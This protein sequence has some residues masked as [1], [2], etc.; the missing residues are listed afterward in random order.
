MKTIFLKDTSNKKLL[1]IREF[2]A[3]LELTWKAWTTKDALDKWWAPKPWKADT[4][5]MD[6]KEGGYW[7][8]AMV[9]PAGEKHWA[10]AEYKKIIPE[11]MYIAYDSFCDENGNK[12]PEPP[13]MEWK[14]N[15]E[16]TATG[17]KVSVEIT[18]A[19]EKD[20]QTI[21]EMGFQEG[22]SMAHENLDELFANAEIKS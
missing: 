14:V 6:F 12:M 3:P 22:F 13:G 5:K 11:K 2:T 19:S 15:F 9:G 4:K 21:V 17:T 7:L 10:L 18:F 8:Y 20:L 1:V 16:K